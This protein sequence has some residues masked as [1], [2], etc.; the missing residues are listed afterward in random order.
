MKLKVC[1]GTTLI[2]K[3]LEGIF[4]EEKRIQILL[5]RY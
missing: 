2:Q 4:N 5:I 1:Y 3:Y